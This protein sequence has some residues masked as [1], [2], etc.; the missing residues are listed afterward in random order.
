[1]LPGLI[2]TP[3]VL[4]MPE[5]LRKATVRAVP[6]GRLGQTSEIA[7]VVAFLASPG[8]SYI[9]GVEIPIDGGLLLGTGSLG[10]RRS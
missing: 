10:Q 8:A 2:A 7:A 3:L 1:M 4:S 9:N 5:E 6:A